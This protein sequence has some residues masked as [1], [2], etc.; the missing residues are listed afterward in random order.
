[1]KTITTL[2]DKNGIYERGG[3][4]YVLGRQPEL[5]GNHFEASAYLP[6]TSEDWDADINDME[7]EYLLNWKVRDDWDGIDGMDACAWNDFR[8]TKIS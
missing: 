1:M 7:T 6:K 3:N 5:N 8:V 4:Q 2:A